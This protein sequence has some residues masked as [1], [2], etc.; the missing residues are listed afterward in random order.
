VVTEETLKYGL[1]FCQMIKIKSAVS[2]RKG[3]KEEERNS[4]QGYVFTNI[5]N[6]P[7]YVKGGRGP[8]FQS[9]P[10]VAICL[11]ALFVL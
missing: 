1:N 2:R 8:K 3:K 10:N 6:G 7:V 9:E 5:T 4:G 11:I